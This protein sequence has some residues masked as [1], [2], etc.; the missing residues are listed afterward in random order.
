MERS[1]MYTNRYAYRRRVRNQ[2]KIRIFNF[3]LILGAVASGG[4]IGILLGAV[5]INAIWPGH[6]VYLAIRT[7]LEALVN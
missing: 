1:S 3:V 5:I 2:R 4:S 6:P 7:A